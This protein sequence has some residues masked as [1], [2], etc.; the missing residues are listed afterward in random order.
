MFQSAPTAY[1]APPRH[2]SLRRWCA[3]LCVLSLGLV[4][5]GD[6][7]REPE[8]SDPLRTAERPILI[9]DLPE[10]GGDYP[11]VLIQGLSRQ[12]ID[13][14]N[15]IEPGVL[16]EFE[17]AQEPGYLYTENNIPLMLRPEALEAAEAKLAAAEASAEKLR[18]AAQ[19]WK[20][21]FTKLKETTDAAAAAAPTA[22]AAPEE[23]ESASA[24][25]L[26][27]AKAKAERY[28]DVEEAR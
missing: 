22:A 4:S 16:V 19:H 12:L 3:A 26:Q 20:Q 15:C 6:A 8:A 21:Q 17:I 25:E 14:M 13:E 7:G 24:A 11:D 18:K 1:V 5:C 27:A 2:R 10:L 28:G 9:A 23:S